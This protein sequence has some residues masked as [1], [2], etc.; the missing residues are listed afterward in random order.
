MHDG[1]LILDQELLCEISEWFVAPKKETDLSNEETTSLEQIKHFHQQEELSKKEILNVFG[2]VS[3]FRMTDIDLERR[4]IRIE[5]KDNPHVS[6]VLDIDVL[7][8]QR[9]TRR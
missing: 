2:G 8:K 9:F 6:Y 4:K 1:Q 5:K 7:E 3:P